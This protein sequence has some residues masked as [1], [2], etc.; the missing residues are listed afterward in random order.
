M[1]KRPANETLDAAIETMPDTFLQ[2]RDFGHSWRPHTARALAKRK[3]YEQTLRCARCL[4]ERR[5]WIDS[6]GEIISSGYE[7]AEGYLVA[8]LG[9]LTGVDRGHVRVA[10][11]LRTLQSSPIPTD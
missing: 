8:G 9:R 6:R 2:C 4:T 5:R 11:V 3:G 10:S 7:Y 1:P